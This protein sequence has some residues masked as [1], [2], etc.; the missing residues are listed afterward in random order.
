LPENL[1]ITRT[2]DLPV[3]DRRARGYPVSVKGVIFV[4]ERVVLLRNE[5]D[6]WELP[7]GK[8]ETGEDPAACVAREILE[9]LGIRVDVAAILDSWLYNIQGRIEV[10]IV[11]YGCRTGDHK[12]TLSHEHKALGLFQLGELDA[13]NMP[14]GYRSSIRTWARV[15]NSSEG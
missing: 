10:L 9:E 11:T 4:G 5:R 13:L 3:T 15:A 8:L 7:G 1:V 2:L 14:E 6:E 12:L